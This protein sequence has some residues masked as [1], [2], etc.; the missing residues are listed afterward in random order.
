[1]NQIEDYTKLESN[2]IFH[3]YDFDFVE[4]HDNSASFVYF[5]FDNIDINKNIIKA[6]D[7]VSN[8]LSKKYNRKNTKSEN[9]EVVVDSFFI[10]N[11]TKKQ[12]KD[13]IHQTT[14]IIDFLTS[15]LR[16]MEKYYISWFFHYFE[17]HWIHFDYFA[18]NISDYK[19]KQLYQNI[20]KDKK[21]DKY[22][23]WN[24]K[25]EKD[26]LMKQ[27]YILKK[28]LLEIYKNYYIIN[29]KFT[30][31]KK[32]QDLFNNNAVNSIVN[33][34]TWLKISFL[35]NIDKQRIVSL[36]ELLIYFPN[37][38]DTLNEMKKLSQNNDQMKIESEKLER[39]IMEINHSEIFDGKSD[40]F[41]TWFIKWKQIKNER[42]KVKNFLL[43][44]KIW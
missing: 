26:W 23:R 40:S 21:N 43:K 29:E 24:I 3:W 17:A 33:K 19:L 14:L 32:N 22:V 11:F 28:M 5:D 27:E 13:W 20:L 35:S 1:M 25:D 34:E 39:E 44:L 36:T 41:I 30:D 31:Y 8:I 7:N 10:F 38:M 15:D 4:L 37:S 42:S 12:V 18:D 9:I 2:E 6:F 16:E